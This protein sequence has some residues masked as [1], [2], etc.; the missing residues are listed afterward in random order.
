MKR[1]RRKVMDA[2]VLD[3]YYTLCREMEIRK[4]PEFYFCEPLPSPLCVGFFKPMVY[5][6]SEEREEKDE[7]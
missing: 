2:A 3:T 5:I 6:N 7:N 4:R 1:N